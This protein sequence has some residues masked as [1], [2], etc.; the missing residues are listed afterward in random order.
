MNTITFSKLNLYNHIRC[1]YFY[2]FWRSGRHTYKRD[3]LRN[4]YLVKESILLQQPGVATVSCFAPVINSREWITKSY[5]IVVNERPTVV[6]GP[7][8]VPGQ[9][10]EGIKADESSAGVFIIAGLVAGMVALI[11]GMALVFFRR[12]R[13]VEEKFAR[14]SD[15]E[16]KAFREGEESVAVSVSGEREITSDR[17]L[18]IEA[19][20]YNPKFEVPRNK[21]TIGELEVFKAVRIQF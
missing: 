10:E 15:A 14:L 7:K 20:P 4:A 5:R 3:K 18:K 11:L 8:A 13:Q 17:D 19:L 21:I 16:I 12:L 2:F 1:K 9:T 6:P